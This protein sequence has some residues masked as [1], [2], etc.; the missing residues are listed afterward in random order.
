[1]THHTGLDNKSNSKNP[2]DCKVAKKYRPRP[3]YCMKCTVC[4]NVFDVCD[5]R[6][7]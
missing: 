7:P 2:L 6:M 3:V 1:M 5:Q 4:F